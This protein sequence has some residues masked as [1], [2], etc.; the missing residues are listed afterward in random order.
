MTKSE[1]T[2][3][4]QDLMM[5]QYQRAVSRNPDFVKKPE[6]RFYDFIFLREKNDNS[7][8]FA[9]LANSP[10]WSLIAKKSSSKAFMV[11]DEA[12][13]EILKSQNL[14][15]ESGIGDITFFDFLKESG[16]KFITIDQLIQ[17]LPSDNQEW[18]KLYDKINILIE[19]GILPLAS[20]RDLAKP[21]VNMGFR[22]DHLETVIV[23][24]EL[25]VIVDQLGARIFNHPNQ[26]LPKF[27]IQGAVHGV[28]I[29]S[30]D[31]VGRVLIIRSKETHGS[32][33]LAQ[34]KKISHQ[35][36]EHQITTSPEV[37]A[38]KVNF[39][40]GKKSLEFAKK[41]TQEIFSNRKTLSSYSARQLKIYRERVT[42]D[43]A[44]SLEKI[45]FIK[46]GSNFHISNLDIADFGVKGSI[47][48]NSWTSQKGGKLHGQ[49]VKPIIDPSQ[50]DDVIEFK[51][52]VEKLSWE[53]VKSLASELTPELTPTKISSNKKITD[54]DLEK[55]SRSGMDY[56]KICPQPTSYL[57]VDQSFHK[58]DSPIAFRLMNQISSAKIATSLLA[59]ASSLQQHSLSQSGGIGEIQRTQSLRRLSL[60]KP[61]S[62]PSSAPYAASQSNTGLKIKKPQ[63]TKDV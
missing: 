17:N 1:F 53:V 35:F 7:D 4:D 48:L 9:L 14:P 22:D 57:G 6:I 5:T 34:R 12:T 25:D 50:I 29:P 61:L 38:S 24:K 39:I 40:Y 59:S 51:I 36:D 11:S 28:N 37:S 3:S 47:F 23:Q 55:L 15:Y 44:L 62:A 33:A 31:G 2:K 26:I 16:F 18:K 41:L 52:K 58:D 8:F 43:L 10:H 19:D 32:D 54:Q 21:I 56:G 27:I 46:Y 49:F 30:D 20:L 60:G 45:A 13:I 63:S 42:R